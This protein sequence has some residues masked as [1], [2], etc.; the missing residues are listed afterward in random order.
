MFLKQQ[1]HFLQIQSSTIPSHLLLHKLNSSSLRNWKGKSSRRMPSHLN[2]LKMAMSSKLRKNAA[3]GTIQFDA[4]SYDKEGSH[5][6][7][8]REKAG[9]DTN[10]DYDQMNAVVTVNVTKTLKLVFGL[11][12]LLCQKIQSLTTLQ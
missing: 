6:Y 10:I 8:V 4:I 5:T 7:T 2:W 3:D 12:R 1:T 11:L 9:T